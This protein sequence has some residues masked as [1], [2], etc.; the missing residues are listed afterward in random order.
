MP[1][2]NRDLQSPAF[3]KSKKNFLLQKPFSGKNKISTYQLLPTKKKE[4]LET[5]TPKKHLPLFS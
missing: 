5:S 2:L 4:K 3:L 1:P